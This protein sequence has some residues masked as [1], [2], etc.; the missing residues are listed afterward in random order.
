[1]EVNV[2]DAQASLSDLIER[3]RAGEEVIIIKAGRPVAR[4]IRVQPD[5]PIL[6]RATGAVE[7]KP[8]W[9][10]PLADDE[11]DEILGA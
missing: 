7:I 6:G 9:D 8:G 3:V 5:T 2:H 1:M 10:D 11:L 4:L